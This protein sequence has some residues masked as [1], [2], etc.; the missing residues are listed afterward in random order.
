MVRESHFWKLPVK[1]LWHRCAT[2]KR[3]TVMCKPLALLSKRGG[4][5]WRTQI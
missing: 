4:P 1:L 2:V 5:L 3:G